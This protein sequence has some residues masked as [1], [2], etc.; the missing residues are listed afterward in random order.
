MASIIKLAPNN[1]Y[2]SQIAQAAAG[3][4]SAFGT[5]ETFDGLRAEA[6]GAGQATMQGIFGALSTGD[7]QALNDRWVNLLD[8][9]FNPNNAAYDEFAVLRDFMNAITFDV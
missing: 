9:T 1:Q 8:A 3:L 5:L 2:G 6:I 4:R 7:A